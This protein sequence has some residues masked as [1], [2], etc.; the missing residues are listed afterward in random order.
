MEYATLMNYKKNIC[1]NYIDHYTE[2][3]FIE[4]SPLPLDYKE[5]ITLDYINCT[6]C[7][8]KDDIRNLRKGKDYVMI[9]PSL[10]NTHMSVLGRVGTEDSFFSFFS[11]MGG[12]KYYSD[13]RKS[14][15]EFSEIIYR[16]FLFLQKYSQNVILTI[17]IQYKDMLEISPQ[18]R[19]LLISQGCII[20]YSENDEE[21]LKWKYGIDKVVG[22]GTRWEIS[23]G[24]DLV[25]WGNTINVFVDDQR[26][27]VDF[28]GGVE[29]LLYA[30]LKLKS[31]IYANDSMTDIVRKF[32]EGNKLREKMIDC[33]V[34]SMCMI[35][36]KDEIILR[37]RYLLDAYMNILSSLM[38]MNDITITEIMGIVEDI[39]SSG[40]SNLSK[41][42]MQA[43]F[44][45]NLN[46]AFHKHVIILNSNNIDGVLRLLNS[47]YTEGNVD[48]AKDKDIVRSRYRMYFSNLSEVELLALHKSKQRSKERECD[49]D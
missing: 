8:A 46:N 48:W 40:I 9:Q 39:N 47:C 12:F 1:S 11:M 49:N 31:A 17:P 35:S 29:T 10:R 38:I 3:G 6:I 28:G 5:D 16:E 21:N 18:I 7:S 2:C 36:S 26:F 25:N 42:D 30:N 22:Y 44:L 41:K 27:G 15:D 20:T 24:G 23:N 45:S 13:M 14:T 34:S 37:D 33:V 4:L 32:C 43:I 19:E